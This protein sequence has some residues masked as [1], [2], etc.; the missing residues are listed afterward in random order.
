MVLC[1]AAALALIEAAFAERTDVFLVPAHMPCEKELVCFSEL[2]KERV[3]VIFPR[4]PVVPK[5][6]PALVYRDGTF[7][8]NKESRW[9][10]AS[11]AAFA[12][13]EFTGFLL[14]SGCKRL[15]VPFAD[16]AA[17]YA[18]AHSDAMR[19]IGDFRASSP[20]AFQL[21]ALFSCDISG[22]EKSFAHIFSCS[23]YVLAGVPENHA[24]LP[25]E[26][27]TREAVFYAA[28]DESEKRFG[29]RTAVFCNDRLT[30]EHF[31][32]FMQKRGTPCP[33]FHGGKTFEE[34]RAAVNAFSAENGTLIAATAVFLPTS[35]F[36]DIRNVI[37]CGVPSDVRFAERIIKAVPEAECL[38]WV[39]CPDDIK[40][41]VGRIYYYAS[42]LP[43]EEKEIFL[44]L[45]MRTLENIL[46]SNIEKGDDF[47]EG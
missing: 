33:V 23:R 43:P 25:R 47:F 2:I 32:A 9:I 46:K 41:A 14:Q 5:N 8:G 45:R 28:A 29:E 4:E 24:V 30:A 1:D 19:Y 37:L 38:P 36:C 42:L 20:E 12:E 6:L 27:L 26:R 18:D 17:L 22:E 16:C 21:I 44:R 15:L 11:S 39:F 10:F 13:N 3:A 7:F 31:A 40:R 34:K 35:L